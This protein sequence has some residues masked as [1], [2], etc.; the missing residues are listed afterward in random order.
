VERRVR[1]KELEETDRGRQESDWKECF[2]QEERFER[3]SESLDPLS[4]QRTLKIGRDAFV[5]LASYLAFTLF[6]DAEF[7][8]EIL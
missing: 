1:R 8:N 6:N 7:S 4:L 2:I 3:D 5:C